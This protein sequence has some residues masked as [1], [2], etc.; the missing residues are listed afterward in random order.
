M[1]ELK[2]FDFDADNFSAPVASRVGVHG[3]VGKGRYMK[4]PACREIPDRMLKYAYA[5]NLANDILPE[6]G[7]RYFVLLDGTFI[8]GDFIEA[9]IVNHNIHVK[10]LIISTLSLSQENVDSLKNLID[11]NFVDQ[12]DMIVSEY[13]FSHERR[14]LIQYMYDTLD[15]DDKF[16]LAVA[17]THCKLAMIETHDGLKITMHGSANLRSSS[18]IE[19]L[20]IEEGAELYNFNEE[21]HDAIIKR[22]QT[23]N[24]PVRFK[25]AWPLMQE[26]ESQRLPNN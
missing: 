4:P 26:K 25:K 5:E 12:L 8:A 10:R 1:N 11:G 21:V 22:Y 13:F 19:Q 16:Q 20:C 24:K 2:Q 15:I 14:G 18:N 17:A 9:F 7:M 3:I 6:K 23:I